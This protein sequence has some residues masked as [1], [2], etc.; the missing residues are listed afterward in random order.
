[1]IEILEDL[2]NLM[3]EKPNIPLEELFQRAVTLV[4]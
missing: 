1:M 4:S 3:R 2:I